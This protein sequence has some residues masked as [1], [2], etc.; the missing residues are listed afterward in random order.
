[1]SPGAPPALVESPARRE[2]AERLGR[3]FKGAMAALRR[4]RGREHRHP[5]EL[6]DAQYSLLF[7][8]RDSCAL[9]TSELATA[10][11]LSPA[12]ATEML[13]GLGAQGL[14]ERVRSDRDRRVVLTSLTDRGHS[15]VEARRTRFEAYYHSAMASFSDDEL[16]TAAAVL[17]RLAV[18]FDEIERQGA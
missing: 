5:G 17:D 4:M 16:R 14:V 18:M 13:D 15:L 1:M 8:L 7:C 12:A 11:D 3:A 2:S 9:P 6:S 10:A